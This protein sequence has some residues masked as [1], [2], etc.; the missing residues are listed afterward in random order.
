MDNSIFRSPE[1]TPIPKSSSQRLIDAGMLHYESSIAGYNERYHRGETSHT[2]H[3]WWARRPHS[4]MRSLIFSSLCKDLSEDASNIM[5][6][7]AMTGDSDS[8]SQANNILTSHY[9]QT[10]RV[11]DMF[12][13]GG[14]IPFEAKKLG[15][16]S[17]SIDANQLSVFIQMC[18]M[19][20]ADLVDLKL[21]AELTKTIGTRVLSNLKEKTAWLYPMRSSSSEKTFGYMWTYETT[22]P[23]CGERFLLIK[24]PWL[25]TKKNRKHV[26]DLLDRMVLNEL[27]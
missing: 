16:D 23:D 5:A 17:H 9:T 8:I 25:S 11:L 4:A 24:R 18:N 14:T 15:L 22:C 6:N 1:I 3:V 13:G 19:H 7:L 10:P 2:I 27:L 20:Y 21:A 12:G 26:L